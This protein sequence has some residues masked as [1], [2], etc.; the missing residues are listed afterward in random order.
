MRCNPNTPPA[1]FARAKSVSPF[2][3]QKFLYG[4][5]DAAD[6]AV[7]SAVLPPPAAKKIPFESNNHGQFP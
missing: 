5:L 7:E 3:E 6:R 1:P 4:M 2:D